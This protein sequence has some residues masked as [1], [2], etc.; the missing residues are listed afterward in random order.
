MST[1][2]TN[3]SAKLVGLLAE[4][5]TVTAVTEAARRV[6]AAGYARWDVHTPFPVHGIDPVIGIRPTRLPWI[7]LCAGLFGLVGGI[8][9]QWYVNAHDYQFLISGKPFWSLPANIPVAFET[10]V[11]CSALTAVFGM[12]LLNR[13]PS[14]YHPLLK[15]DRFRRATSDRFFIVIDATDQRFSADSAA[16][17][18]LDAGATAVERVED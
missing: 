5:P 11:L 12:L 2:A 10:T 18:F 13:L 6:R 4:F 15:I 9:L 16:K 8:T 7:V 1:S 17:L 3:A 14:H